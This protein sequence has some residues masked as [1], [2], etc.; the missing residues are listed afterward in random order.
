[1]YNNVRFGVGCKGHRL[2]LYEGLMRQGRE[3]SEAPCLLSLRDYC[4]SLYDRLG[5]GDQGIMS[6]CHRDKG[7][8]FVQI[9]DFSVSLYDANQGLVFLPK[10]WSRL[11]RAVHSNLHENLAVSL[12]RPTVGLS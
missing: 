9:R 12:V 2:G 8:C 5:P 11:S 10:S 1:M 7:F 6:L 3:I 4:S